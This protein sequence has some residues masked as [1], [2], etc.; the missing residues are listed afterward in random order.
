MHIGINSLTC[1]S[2]GS[3]SLPEL[4]LGSMFSQERKA[5]SGSMWGVSPSGVDV[6]DVDGLLCMWGMLVHRLT[7]PIV[8]STRGEEREE[9][10]K[11]GKR[12]RPW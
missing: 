11:H 10:K 4:L 7:F 6:E 8:Q 12:M 2:A 9:R 3:S 1:S 5:A